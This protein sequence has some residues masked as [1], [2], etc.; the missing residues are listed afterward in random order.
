MKRILIAGGDKRNIYL[1]RILDTEGFEVKACGFDLGVNLGGN[2]EIAT[3]AKKAAM[4]SDVIIFGLP[5]SFDNITVNTPHCEDCIYLCDILNSANKNA[6]IAGG[7]ISEELIK[8]YGKEIIDYSKRDDFAYLNAVPTAEG[9]IKACMDELPRTIFGIKCAVT[10]FG[11]CAEVLSVMLKSLNAD[12][13]VF[14]RSAKDLAHSKA[15][16]IKSFHLTDLPAMSKDFDAVF[17][18]VPFGIFSEECINNLKKD[19][20]FIDIASAPGGICNDSLKEKIKYK[21][22]P[23]LPGKY[24]P[25]TAAEIIKNVI[26]TIIRE[27]GKDAYG[28]PLTDSK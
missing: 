4:Q 26:L 6:V 14:A 8:K 9:A 22:L 7:R 5:A 16:G 25:Y 27:S 2:I 11:K 20:V 15:L 23:G 10:G 3:N 17:N 24:S 18:T 21:F 19:C 13:V 1:A 12:P 28:W